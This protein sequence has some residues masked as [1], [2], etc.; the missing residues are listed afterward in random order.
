MTTPVILVPLDGSTHAL[1][2]LPVAR[3]LAAVQGALIHVLHV[4]RR[5]LPPE[6][7]LEAIKLTPEELHGSV[8]DE[9][10]GEPADAILQVSREM[11]DPVIV[12]CTHT[13]LPC[14]TGPL[15]MIAEQGL[16]HSHCPIV[17]VDPRR[18]FR[19]WEMRNL[20]VPHDGTPSTTAAIVPAAELARQANAHLM[21]LHVAS[22]GM[23]APAE[24]GSITAPRYMDQP[25]HEWP[26]W[27]SEFL[28]RLARLWPLESLQLKLALRRGETAA[29]AVRFAEDAHADLIL[30]VW[31]G[32]I[33][34][35]HASVVR[36]VISEA[37]CPTM[38]L[39]T[40]N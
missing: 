6:R 36:S 15:G 30:L 29:A 34:P 35:Q 7:V 32:D 10:M 8:L 5:A 40:R 28:G 1:S 13:G 19:P 12:M 33:N 17:L 18:G 23:V 26:A 21:V 39:R 16:L 38:V 31:H 22:Q 24:P 14:P 9:R 27:A 2:A 3:G 25:Q 20:L 37:P 11:H 4:S